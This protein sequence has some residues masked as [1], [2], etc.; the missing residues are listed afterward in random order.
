MS[1]KQLPILPTASAAFKAA[2]VGQSTVRSYRSPWR[3]WETW[4]TSNA[5]DPLDATYGDYQSYLKER[6]PSWGKGREKMTSVAISCVYRYMGKHNPT[7]PTRQ[8]ADVTTADYQNWFTRFLVWCEDHGKTALPA[9]PEAV[10]VFLKEVSQS[11][12]PYKTRRA[13]A[14]IG[15]HHQNKGYPTPTDYPEVHRMMS[16]LEDQHPHDGSAS[17]RT[18]RTRERNRNLWTTW[19]QDQGIDP[20]DPTPDDI[21][22]YVQHHAKRVLRG[23]VQSYVTAI[24]PMLN[25]PSHA[26]SDAVKR[27]IAAVPKSR[28]GEK[29]LTVTQQEV[30]AETEQF[31]ELI[32]SSSLWK[33]DVPTYLTPEQRKRITQAMMASDV[34]EKTFDSYIRVGWIPM[35]KWCHEMGITIETAETSDVVAFLCDLAARVSPTSAASARNALAYCYQQ[36][37]PLSNPADN[38]DAR[39]AVRG[40]RR[41]NPHAPSQVD[42]ITQIEFE[43]I[44]ATAHCA[45][46]KERPP[47]TRLRAAVDIAM[48]GTMRDCMLRGKEAAEARWCDIDENRDGTGTL[49]IR[50]SKTDQFSEGATGHLSK[51]TMT[52]L[53]TMRQAMRE[54]GIKIAEDDLIFRMSIKVL[55]QRIKDACHAAGLRGRYSGHSPRVGMTQDL[56][57]ANASE[58]NIAHA[59]RWTNGRMPAYYA[60][61]IKAS[62]NAVAN[63]HARGS[64]DGT[65]KNPNPL[66]AYGLVSDQISN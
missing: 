50:R 57:I 43:M 35:K 64:R 32:S 52:D 10:V 42:P 46:H 2:G 58:V 49:T 18:I 31:L 29:P 14:S 54:V 40:L 33:G 36:I 20:L 15:W 21:C 41:G 25:N 60:R 19:S 7:R 24:A 37:R 65:E 63:W 13:R 17:P 9:K 51:Q 28:Q 44:R 5:V 3:E 16:D 30:E 6:S 59:G 27:E 12:P 11:Y 34:A 23:T 4:S 47:D 62:K 45:R 66:S 38:L 55:P 8:L 39:K 22:T 1:S 26:K 61:K 56:T 48:I 53:C